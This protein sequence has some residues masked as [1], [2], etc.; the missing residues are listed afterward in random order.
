MP[1]ALIIPKWQHRHADAASRN[2]ATCNY[3]Q[4]PVDMSGSGYRRLISGIDAK[5]NYLGKRRDDGAIAYAVYG[6]LVS[7]A[8]NMPVRGLLAK[9]HGPLSFRDIADITRHPAERVEMAVNILLLAEEDRE[10]RWLEWVE[11][12]FLWPAEFAPTQSKKRKTIDWI[13][14]ADRSPIQ[15]QSNGD[16]TPIDCQSIA[17]KTPIDSQSITDRA[18]ETKRKE[19]KKKEANPPI[20][21]AIADD[22]TARLVARGRWLLA[23]SKRFAA[24]GTEQRAADNTAATRMFDTKIWPAGMA[25]GA[26]ESNLAAAMQAVADV[27]AARR[28]MAL[29]TD[30]IDHLQPA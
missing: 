29:L 15:R 19:E 1:K 16:R 21:R 13:Q 24:N 20:P 2:V 23:A 10:V 8:A 18:N 9:E 14:I 7:L 11:L 3:A 25:R 28:P 17:D 27:A 22:A 6:S 5:G 30:K 12:P 26:G 4:W